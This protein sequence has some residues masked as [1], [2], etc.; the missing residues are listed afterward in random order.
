M[1]K[2]WNCYKLPSK[3]SINERFFYNVLSGGFY[4]Q[5]PLQ[6][7]KITN[8]TLLQ[9]GTNWEEIQNLIKNQKVK[10]SRKMRICRPERGCEIA[11]GYCILVMPFSALIPI[12]FFMLELNPNL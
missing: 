6:I 11:T 9:E 12:D 1:K 2:R 8:Q 5:T 3:T 4:S 10:S 7:T